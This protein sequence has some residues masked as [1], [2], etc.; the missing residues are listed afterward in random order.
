MKKLLEGLV[1]FW[2]TYVV[3]SQTDLP[4]SGKLD[5][6]GRDY[7]I[8]RSVFIEIPGYIREEYTRCNDFLSQGCNEGEYISNYP[9]KSH[10][11]SSKEYIKSRKLP[12]ETNDSIIC[13]DTQKKR[14][15]NHEKLKLIKKKRLVPID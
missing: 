15:Y 10:C 6:I 14:D 4:G 3:N 2:L 8:G 1:S 5:A 9:S 7:Q 11:L 12:E 13:P